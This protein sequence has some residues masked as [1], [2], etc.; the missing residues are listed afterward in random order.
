MVARQL[1]EVGVA[2]TALLVNARKTTLDSLAEANP[3]ELEVIMN[4]LPPMG[5]K[6]RNAA[7][8]IAK[9]RVSLLKVG[10]DLLEAR[11]TRI[12]RPSH[13]RIDPKKEYHQW[14]VLI[15][16]GSDDKLLFQRRFA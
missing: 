15:V 3:R 12:V 14:F 10:S 1:P 7:N 2:L 4:R 16:G 13:P 9:L 11:V 5:D 6:V 8:D